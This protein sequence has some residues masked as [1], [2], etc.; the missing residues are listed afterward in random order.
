LAR[1][2]SAER[3]ILMGRHKARTDLGIKW[4]ATDV[5]GERGDEGVSIAR[6]LAGGHGVP[7]VLEAVG[8]L[9]AY[10]QAMGIVRPAAS[11]AVSMF[12]STTW[13]RSVLRNSSTT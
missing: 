12:R 2:L 3:I 13:L 8:L 1:K 4:G 5:V 9:P 10:E 6:D 7:K 11:S